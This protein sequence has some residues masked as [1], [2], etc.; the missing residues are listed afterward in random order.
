[1]AEP[2]DLAESW[3]LERDLS[4]AAP[5]TNTETTRIPTRAALKKQSAKYGTAPTVGSGAGENAPGATGGSFELPV[6]KLPNRSV[7]VTSDGHFQQLT[8]IVLQAICVEMPACTT[9]EFQ[10]S[11]YTNFAPSANANND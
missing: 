2:V 4:T 3:A 11:Y 6:L 7:L 1:M 5:Q 9:G 10:H 8:V